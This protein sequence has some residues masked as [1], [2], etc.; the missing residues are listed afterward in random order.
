MDNEGARVAQAPLKVGQCSVGRIRL[1]AADK[2][3][4]PVVPPPDQSRVT[5]KN[6][7]CGKILGAVVFPQA[8]RPPQGGN[9][10]LRRY[11]GPAQSSHQPGLGQALA[12]LAKLVDY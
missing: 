1:A 5:G 9:P 3:P 2:L 6:L 7:R 4:P 8:I 10:R 12:G 11:A